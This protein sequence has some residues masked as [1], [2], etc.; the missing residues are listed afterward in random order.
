MA[1]R[2]QHVHAV[3]AAGEAVDQDDERAAG[4][5]LGRL[6]EHAEQDVAGAIGHRKADAL[7]GVRRHVGPRRLQEQGQGL[8]IGAPPR[9]A[10]LE[11]WQVQGIDGRGHADSV[12]TVDWP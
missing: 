8:E 9:E 1:G 5:G 2:A 12:F 4:D 6:I 11:G 7:A 3:L 10:W